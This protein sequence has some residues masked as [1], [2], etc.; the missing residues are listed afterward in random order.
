MIDEENLAPTIVA[1]EHGANHHA[2]GFPALPSSNYVSK[3]VIASQRVTAAA[4]AGGLIASGKSAYTATPAE[5]V[6]AYKDVFA[7]L[8]AAAEQ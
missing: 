2:D 1:Q 8:E 5:A 6:R 7:E 4:L 3:E